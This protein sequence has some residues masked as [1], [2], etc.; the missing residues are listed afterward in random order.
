M[1]T[2]LIY[3]QLTFGGITPVSGALKSSFPDVEFSLGNIFPYGII[4][5]FFALIAVII[6]FLTKSKGTKVVF[7][8]LSLSSLVHAVYLAM[9]QDGMNWY[10]ITG[11]LIFALVIGYL[12]QI[13][14][15]KFF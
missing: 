4:T 3:N 14:N 15:I 10:Y 6:V 5:S 8:L 11:Y 12:I 7:I 1:V 2:Y 13:I 9:F